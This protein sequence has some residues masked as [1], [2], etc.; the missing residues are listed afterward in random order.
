MSNDFDFN[1]P[2]QQ[3]KKIDYKK[4]FFNPQEGTNNLRIV[5]LAGKSFKVHYVKDINQKNVFVKS[6]GP[7][8]PLVVEG[9]KPRTRYYLKVIDRDSNM[10]KVWEFGS[11]IRQAIEEYITDLKEER[12]KSGDET[13][14]L[15]NYDLVLRKRKP[16]SNPLYTLSLAQ[17]VGKETLEADQVII[18]ND[19]IDF[20]PLLRP[21]SIERIK[22]QILGIKDGET[23]GGNADF[24]VDQIEKEA[25]AEDAE[26][27]ESAPR[28]KVATASP[29]ETVKAAEN[30][31]ESWLDD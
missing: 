15:N 8:D 27:A 18:D 17:K 7:G 23:G 16:Q 28:E 1:E 11:Q 12:S 21:W 13:N 26:K 4:T 5:D 3:G 22:E 19:D 6:P 31:S 10:L 25:A 2:R 24:N 29:K 14:T 9:N 20:E 30:A